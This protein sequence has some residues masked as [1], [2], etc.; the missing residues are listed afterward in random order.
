MAAQPYR[1]HSETANL[2]HL[3]PQFASPVHSLQH[4]NSPLPI[5]HGISESHAE[6]S[7]VEA[8]P[9]TSS[10][11]FSSQETPVFVGQ[12]SS[13]STSNSLNANTLPALK[14]KSLAES[15]KN[16]ANF[17][18]HIA[19]S[20]RTSSGQIKRSSI[21]GT[22]TS[23]D[24]HQKRSGHSRTSSLLSNGSS[25]TEVSFSRTILSLRLV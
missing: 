24:N 25:I 3:S 12:D 2:N 16:A 8:T 15:R 17:P 19:A 13:I 9:P 20:K 10:S 14:S 22:D 1:Q 23:V 5:S 21:L 6:T 4:E 11:G 18:E 7:D